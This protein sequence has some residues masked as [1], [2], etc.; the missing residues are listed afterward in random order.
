MAG[1]VVADDNA[2]GLRRCNVAGGVIRPGETCGGGGQIVAGGRGVVQAHKAPRH[3][4]A[5]IGSRAD[6][7]RNLLDQGFREGADL[8][9]RPL[10]GD[11]DGLVG[12]SLA[13]YGSSPPSARTGPR[14]PRHA[15]RAPS[16]PRR[17][18]RSPWPPGTGWRGPSCAGNAAAKDVG[19]FGGS[20]VLAQVQAQGSRFPLGGQQGRVEWL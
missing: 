1:A 17:S 20:E 18:R 8:V 15:S 5:N 6:I 16:N 7:D 10:V 14:P 2:G 4:G 11:G 3:R 9:L 19:H 12:D 13:L